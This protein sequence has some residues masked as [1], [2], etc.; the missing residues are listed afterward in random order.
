LL[1]LVRTSLTQPHQ[2]EYDAAV[3]HR[4][5]LEKRTMLAPTDLTLG[6]YTRCQGRG[7][8]TERIVDC[9]SI[10]EALEM[11]EVDG[12]THQ[13]KRLL[14]PRCTLDHANRARVW[15]DLITEADPQPDV[16][17]PELTMYVVNCGECPAEGKYMCGTE[18]EAGNHFSD[19]GWTVLWGRVRCPEHLS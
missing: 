18:R 3:G 4:L 12:W 14:C 7:C 19:I 11:L 9:N 16:D 8:V 6:L 17:L 13:R 5:S 1:F 10:A 15:S 2:E